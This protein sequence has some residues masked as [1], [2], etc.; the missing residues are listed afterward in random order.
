MFCRY[1]EVCN[2]TLSGSDA[3]NP[4]KYVEIAMKAAMVAITKSVEA[5]EALE[6]SSPVKNGTQYSTLETCREVLTDCLEQVNTSLSRV[7]NLNLNSLKSE[8]GDIQQYMAAALTYQDTC[9]TGVQDFGLWNGSDALNGTYGAYATML[10]SNSLSLVNSLAK[11]TNWGQV[12]RHSRRLL[13]HGSRSFH[14][15]EEDSSVGGEFPHWFSR[16]G[17]RLLQSTNPTPDAVVAIDGSGKFKSIQAAVDA[18][19]SKG[20][21]RWVIYVKK[22]VYSE[23]VSISKGNKNLMMYGD[24]PGQTIIT[25]SKSVK[26]SGVTTFLSATFGNSPSNSLSISPASV[27]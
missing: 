3:S 10:L 4:Q 15:M 21:A 7:S 2:N 8:V 5:V 19:P 11:I 20:T 12:L 25:G 9:L 17:R 13:A 14:E 27:S 6:L 16:E 22:G 26:G 18:A 1:P 24:G 23:Y